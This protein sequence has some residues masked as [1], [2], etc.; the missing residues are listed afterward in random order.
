MNQHLSHLYLQF[1]SQDATYDSLPPIEQSRVPASPLKHLLPKSPLKE[2]MEPSRV[3]KSPLKD[4]V[5]SKPP[6]V[7][8]SPDLPVKKPM[9]RRLIPLFI[10]LC[11]P[12]KDEMRNEGHV[13]PGC[14]E[15]PITDPRMEGMI[16]NPE[17]FGDPL[18]H[19]N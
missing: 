19:I 11:D 5:D 3:P 17:Y 16:S 6:I 15:D 9:S 2:P 4:P 13:T 14:I 10:V 18:M 12:G 7:S 1:L 8:K